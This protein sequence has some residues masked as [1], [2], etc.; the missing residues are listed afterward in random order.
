MIGNIS[1]VLITGGTGLIGRHLAADLLASGVETWILTRRP[2]AAKAP[3]GARL[4][5]W[6]G[7]TSEGWMNLI[8]RVQAV[9]NLAGE[10]LGASPW[11]EER[12]Q[13]IIQSRIMAGQAVTETIKAGSS[14]PEVFVQASAVG[15]YGIAGD[16]VKTEDSPPGDDF[17]AGVCLAW[18]ASTRVVEDLGVR[19]VVMRTGVVLDRDEGALPRLAL[20]VKMYAGGP[21]GSG[22]QWLSWVHIRDV[23]RGIHFF[24]ENGQVRGAANLTSPQPLQNADFEKVLADVLHRPDWLPVPAF[25]L[26]LMLGKMSTVVLD[27]QRVIPA[28]LE[29]LGFTFEFADPRAALENIYA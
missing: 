2:E 12:R 14:R 13:K 28:R 5:R 10:N 19:R 3:E 9:V 7:R 23:V 20:P 25:A 8:D 16:Q 6:D 29:R 26:K 11:T 21:L 24:L 15:Y 1:A 22:K 27:G 17:Q 4:V 18:E